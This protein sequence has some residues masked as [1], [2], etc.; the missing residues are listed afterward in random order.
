MYQKLRYLTINRC[1]F[2]SEI[3]YLND[4]HNAKK[5]FIK[6]HAKEHYL[7]KKDDFVVNNNH[8]KQYFYTYKYLMQT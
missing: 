6:F 7:C 1:N 3:E 2:Q 4:V 8:Y 5:L